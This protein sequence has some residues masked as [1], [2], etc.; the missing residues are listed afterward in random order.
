MRAWSAVFLSAAL[1]AAPSE[2]PWALPVAVKTLPNGLTVVVSEDHR[3]PVV[4][5]SVV[6]KVG[7]R[8]EPKGRTGFAHLFEHLMFEGTPTAPKGVFDRVIEG[9]GGRNNGSTRQDYTNYVDEVP[10]S[11]LEPV[12]WLE[13]DRMRTLDFSE[14]N[15][16][17][18]QEVVKEEIRVNVKNQPYGLFFWIDMTALSFDKWENAHDGYGSFKDL[19][20]AAL[21]DVETFHQQFYG[22]NNA[23]LSIAGDLTPE[24]GFA[25]AEKYFGALPSRPVPAPADF[26]EGLAAQER[27]LSQT[28]PLAKI[29]GLAVGWRMPAAGTPDHAPAVVLAQLLQG[30]DASRLY[31]AL[32]KG[33]ALMVSLEGGINWPLSTPW[34]YRGP[35]QMTLFGTYKP[36]VKA[37]AILEVLDAEVS[38]VA[39]EG[40]PTAELDRVKTLMLSQFYAGLEGPLDRAD[41]LALAEALTGGASKLNDVPA[42]IK[43]VTSA[44]LQRVAARYLT[45]A[46]RA[47]IDRLPQ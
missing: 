1:A 47:V 6:Y 33:K 44:D 19:D 45:R 38:R 7:M 10:V 36:G 2:K 27:R 8:L 26:T 21:A 30:G 17:N 12:L 22:P 41:A 13:A 40:V 34:A 32:V 39:K 28:D 37:D 4:G 23:V 3:A 29:P 16:H 25:L 43:A 24:Q 35:V 5:V 20:T 11:A 46:N 31:L 18:Q 14:R 9:G 42:R 15:L